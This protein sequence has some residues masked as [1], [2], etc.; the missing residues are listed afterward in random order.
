MIGYPPHFGEEVPV[1]SAPLPHPPRADW[2]SR[3]A[4][5]TAAVLLFELCTGLAVTFGPFHPAVEWGLILHTVA[6][7]LTLAPLSW[8]FVRHWADYAGQAMSDVKL[9]GYVGLVALAVCTLS[10]VVVTWQ[11]LFGMRTDSLWRYAPLVSTLLAMA[12]TLPHI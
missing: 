9:L 10:G 6:G 12:A 11:G 7:V 5:V 4:R 3:L 1:N 8:Y 2:A